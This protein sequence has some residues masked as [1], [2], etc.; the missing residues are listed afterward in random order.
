MQNQQC[1]RKSNSLTMAGVDVKGQL[2][3]PIIQ[4]NGALEQHFLPGRE[5]DPAVEKFL[6]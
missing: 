3:R 2:A 6:V 5:G 1:E 4:P